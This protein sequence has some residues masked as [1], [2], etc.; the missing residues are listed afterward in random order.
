M[1]NKHIL[2]HTGFGECSE[3]W[4]VVGMT[5]KR[6]AVVDVL[7]CPVLLGALFAAVAPFELCRR[8]GRFLSFWRLRLSRPSCYRPVSVPPNT[9]IPHPPIHP[10]SSQFLVTSDSVFPSPIL[11]IPSPVPPASSHGG[12]S[13]SAFSS[14]NRRSLI[15]FLRCKILGLRRLRAHLK[16]TI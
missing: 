8:L 7:L 5:L 16:K 6:C 4:M 12:S 1:R 9:P 15:R 3:A 13:F 10:R 11:V 14:Y 2:E